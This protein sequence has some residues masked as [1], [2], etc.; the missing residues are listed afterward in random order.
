MK[1]II[2]ENDMYVLSEKDFKSFLE[3]AVLNNKDITNFTVIDLNKPLTFERGYLIAES[4][5][6]AKEYTTTYHQLTGYTNDDMRVRQ[7]LS[8]WDIL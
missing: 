4:S 8:E 3:V 5:N 2:T 6:L 1:Y 7:S